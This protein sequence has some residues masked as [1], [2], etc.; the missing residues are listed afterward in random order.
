V[1]LLSEPRDVTSEW[2]IVQAKRW[3]D[4]DDG[5][6][7]DSVLVYAAVELRAAIERTLFELLYLLKEQQV[8]EEDIL[9]AK[10]LKGIEALLREADASY[11][12]T[13]E[14]THLVASMTPGLPAVSAV[15]TAYLR[16]RWSD[17]SE[18]C[19]FQ[20]APAKTFAAPN[21][22]FQRR[23]FHLVREVLDRFLEW[24]VKSSMGLIQRSSMPDE[25]RSIYDKFVAHQIDAEQA[26]RMLVIAEPALRQRLGLRS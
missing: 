1:K 20:I 3:L 12:K 13:I 5:R 15:D 6:E 25:T 17:L 18:Y 7:F 24:R 11:R 21:R 10:S 14:F 22:E 26:K 16:R 4:F 8:T 2:H 9:R 19:H 23:G